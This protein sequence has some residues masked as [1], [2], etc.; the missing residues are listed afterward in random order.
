V[1]H[2]ADR[3]SGKLVEGIHALMAEFYSANL[4]TEIRKGMRQKAKLGGWPYRAPTGYRNTRDVVDG[5]SVARI[6]PDPERAPLITLAFELYATG[7]YTLHQLADELDRRG[8]RSRSKTRRPLSLNGIST[9]LH[10]TAYIGKVSYQGV[11][12]DGSHEPLI[13]DSTFHAVQRLLA[14]RAVRGTRERKHPHHLKGLLYCAICDRRLSVHLAKNQYRYF[15]CLGQKRQRNRPPTGCREPFAP[16][17]RVEVEL[18]RLYQRVQLPADV[19]ARIEHALGAEIAA[20]QQRAVDDHQRNTTRLAALDGERHK[21][22]DAYYH[23]AIPL[24]L[25]KT[26]QARITCEAHQIQQQLDAVDADLDQWQQILAIATRFAANCH[27]AYR[28]ATPTAKRQLNH[29]VFKRITLRDGHIHRWEFQPPFDVVL[30][31]TRF[32]YGSYVELTLIIQ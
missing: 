22:L 5:R 2:T 1:P 32:E 11:E 29:A 21:L 28:A 8:L 24:E 17:D 16:T 7:E 27:A 18:D 10:N 3:T 9:L 31:P 6:V 25:L 26:E 12:H 23:D 15:F 4:A 19:V 13:D 20:R 30:E 14:A